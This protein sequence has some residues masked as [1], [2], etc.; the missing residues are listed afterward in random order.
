MQLL[1]HHRTSMSPVAIGHLT[2]RMSTSCTGLG[3]TKEHVQR[4]LLKSRL[5]WQPITLSTI[6]KDSPLANGPRSDTSIQPSQLCEL[7]QDL[8]GG[9]EAIVPLT[10]RHRLLCSL[11][12]ET[13]QGLCEGWALGV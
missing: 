5:V 4:L 3:C 2:A 6:A 7:C 12:C 8:R 13:M 11:G 10:A 1:Q 9:L